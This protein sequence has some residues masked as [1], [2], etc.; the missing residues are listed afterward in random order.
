MHCGIALLNP[1]VKIVYPFPAAIMSA[2]SR[3]V[4]SPNYLSFPLS[5][6]ILLKEDR[7]VVEVFVWSYSGDRRYTKPHVVKDGR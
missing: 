3:L 5:E 2:L 7:N 1:R 4:T 6:S